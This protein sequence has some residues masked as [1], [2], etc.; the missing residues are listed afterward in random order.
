MITLLLVLAWIVIG[1]GGFVFW[2]TKDFDF[3][4]HDIFF[5]IS[6]GVALGPFSW[7]IGFFI[8]GNSITQKTLFKK[9]T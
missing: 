3:T 6:T 1:I 2:W 4:T 8:H 5:G 9:R 7:I